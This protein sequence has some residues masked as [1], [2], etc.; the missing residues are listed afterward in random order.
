MTH[1]KFAFTN[2]TLIF[3]KTRDKMRIIRNYV[4]WITILKNERVSA[5]LSLQYLF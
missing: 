2:I 5:N 1:K 4:F 3:A